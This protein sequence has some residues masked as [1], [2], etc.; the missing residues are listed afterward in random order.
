MWNF[1]SQ[2][3]KVKSVEKQ[4]N[5]RWGR[6]QVGNRGAQRK[7]KIKQRGKINTMQD[8]LIGQGWSN[9]MRLRR[10]NKNGIVL[11]CMGSGYSTSIHS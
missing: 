11:N 4:K 8:P 2:K 6:W 9:Q 7:E 5:E 10:G 3:N 1:F